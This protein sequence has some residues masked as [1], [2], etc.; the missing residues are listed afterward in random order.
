MHLWNRFL[1]FNEPALLKRGCGR[2]GAYRG[3][4]RFLQPSHS[5][6]A[7]RFTW[8]KQEN[9]TST[10]FCFLSSKG[11]FPLP[12]H[13]SLPLQEKAKHF[14][15]DSVL[16]P[17]LPWCLPLTANRIVLNLL[18]SAESVSIPSMLRKYGYDA[19][20]ALSVYGVLTGMAMPFL[21]FPNALTSSVAIL[22]LPMVS[23]AYENNDLSSIRK[24]ISQGD[25]LWSVFWGALYPGLFALGKF[26]GKFYLSQ[27]SCGTF[28]H[29]PGLFVPLLLL[30]FH[31][32]Q[33]PPGPGKG[34]QPF[35]HEPVLLKPAA[36][37]RL[38]GHSPYRDSGVPVG[39]FP[40]PVG[41]DLFLSS[42]PALYTATQPNKTHFVATYSNSKQNFV[43]VH[44]RPLIFPLIE[45]DLEILPKSSQSHRPFRAF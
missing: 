43:T 13:F 23:E 29:F 25:L 21:F 8:K 37:F 10:S 2:L 27:R 14:L 17:C 45:K 16:F 20:T 22:L 12:K 18:Q 44:S 32:L 31:P 30:R 36:F 15:S 35:C 19:A 9:R 3:R 41:P 6:L 28:Y 5:D 39:D 34:G 40:K 42:F 4:G 24:S 7:W 38:L 1:S 33:Y 26:S 11:P